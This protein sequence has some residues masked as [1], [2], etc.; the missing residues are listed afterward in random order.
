[1]SICASCGNDSFGASILGTYASYIRTANRNS[2]RFSLNNSQ[3]SF[4]M[5]GR[6]A[7]SQSRWTRG[8]VYWKN[9]C[10]GCNCVHGGWRKG[11]FSYW[12]R[13]TYRRANRDRYGGLGGGYCYISIRK[14][15]K[16]E[17]TKKYV[18]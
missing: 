13:G 15:Y 5:S 14:W 11:S 18:A 7:T 16:M 4:G 3:C 17:N 12:N 6:I 2:Q 8:M 10:V 9:P 1:M